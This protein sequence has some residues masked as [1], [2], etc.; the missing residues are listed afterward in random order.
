[1]NVTERQLRELIRKG[2]SLTTEFKACGGGLSRD[3][4]ETV[5]A[6]LNRHG[7]TILL[8]VR[9]DGMITGLTPD[10]TEQ[11]RKDFVT[12]INN[13]QK[14]TPPTYLSI[15]P[16]EVDGKA[17]LHIYVPESSQVHRCSGRIYDRNEDGDLDITDHTAEVA[18]LYQR[19]QATY[20]E[21]KVYP[22]IQVADLRQD[23]IERC[24]NHA[25]INRKNHPWVEMDDE[26]LL[27]SAQLYQ[28][29]LESGRLGV[30][31][32]GVML[33]GTDNQILQV[34]PAHRTDL[35][36]RKV[37]VNRYD[38]RDLVRTNLIDSYDRILDFIRKHLP[39]PF[40][41]EG[42]ER[43]SI[44]EAIFREVASN[45]LIHR[46]Y[47]SGVPARLIIEY[48]K[49]TTY[50]ANRPH[51]FG[52]LDP[53]TSAPYPKNPIIGAF[54]R[55]IDRADELGSGMRNMMLYGKKYG[56]EDPQLIEGD[57]FQMVI[58]VPEFSEEAGSTNGLAKGLAEPPEVAR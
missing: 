55:E 32:A 17:L 57:V 40:Y 3:V 12:A 50:N 48:R 45:M 29:D 10:A 20:S 25:R 4:Y 9:D 19:K 11:L 51:G 26:Q 18:R 23:L 2:E 53:E 56:G 44:R 58:S 5:C 16:A 41:L 22:H 8:G 47:A 28:P 27:K 49:V 34:C 30:T 24:R 1:M 39:D 46:E 35:I 52:V 38:D 33:F 6:F 42:I 7:G 21:N 37:N 43:K 36:L 13:P 14:L 31:L 54:F 15:G